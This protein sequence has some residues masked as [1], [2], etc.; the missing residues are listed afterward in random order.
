MY[1]RQKFENMSSGELSQEIDKLQ[2]S[3]GG[4]YF[5]IKEENSSYQYISYQEL[6]AICLKSHP[7]DA[8]EKKVLLEKIKTKCFSP[9][10]WF[11]NIIVKIYN[12]FWNKESISKEDVYN[13]LSSTPMRANAHAIA[14]KFTVELNKVR[15]S[16]K[17]EL[18]KRIESDNDIKQIQAQISERENNIKDLREKSKKQIEPITEKELKATIGI[19]NP[20]AVIK[21]LESE[22]VGLQEEMDKKLAGIKAELEEKHIGDF[23]A[24]IS[25]NE[26]DRVLFD[27]IDARINA[28]EVKMEDRLVQILNKNKWNSSYTYKQ[29]Y[30]VS[31][32]KKDK[33]GKEFQEHITQYGE[34]TVNNHQLSSQMLSIF[35]EMGSEEKVVESFVKALISI[36]P[37]KKL[38]LEFVKTNL[39][40][41]ARMQNSRE[42]IAAAEK[43]I[44]KI[45]GMDKE[46]TM[47]TITHEEIE[48]LTPLQALGVGKMLEKYSRKIGIFQSFYPMQ[49]FAR[50]A[51]QLP[52][53]LGA[54][55][56]HYDKAGYTAIGVGCINRYYIGLCY[57]RIYQLAKFTNPDGEREI[58]R[59]LAIVFNKSSWGLV[60]SPKSVHF[61]NKIFEAYEN[62]EPQRVEQMVNPTEKWTW[63]SDELEVARAGIKA[64]IER[65]N[66]AGVSI[67]KDKRESIEKGLE[68]LQS[69]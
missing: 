40:Q 57:E 67:P 42:G 30:T 12:Y 39:L 15:D 21:K 43:L 26:N 69:K 32:K 33:N 23:I 11:F 50:A 46:F 54:A 44:A 36:I 25:L 27:A 4:H 45:E 68:N 58:R 64:S 22:I 49:C 66:S 6:A 24:K 59:G 1:I 29:A 17:E 61:T 20:E 5:S 8:S 28:P 7:K 34:V 10:G 60:E 18:L 37:H 38:C 56:E 19:E 16:I 55:L 63:L 35:N 47:T 2:S 31:V 3:W 9:K 13:V 65:L 53:G 14:D 48:K 51:T 52:E 62:F 41:G